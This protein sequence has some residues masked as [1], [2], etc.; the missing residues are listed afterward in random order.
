MGNLYRK[1]VFDKAGITTPPKTWAEF[2]K[3]AATIKAK[4]GSYISNMPGSDPG[5]LIGL[6]W[7]NGA[8]PF[9]YDGKKTLS[10][11][12]DSSQ[13]QQVV[14]FWQ[15]LIHKGQVASAPDFNND[16]YKALTNGN[17]ASWQTAAWAPVF[18]QSAVKS[19][20]GKWRAATLPQWTA[21]ANASGNWG[22]SS[23]AVLTGSKN[24]AAA[25]A[26]A[27]FINSD[28]QSTQMLATEQLLF[29]VTNA[30]LQSSAFID[31]KPS[32]YG[33]QQV[34]KQFSDISNTVDT[35]FEWPPITDYLFSSY[36]TTLGKA[37]ANKG[38]MLAGLT[39]WQNAVVA[40]AK[41]QGFTV[42]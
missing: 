39:D 4:T 40:Y 29:P 19:T 23:D 8:K 26:L 27:K 14:K 41:Q 37:I 5:Q 30:T 34:N 42:K 9:S 1:D 32:F 3:D 12:L 2:A 16:W 7:Q 13:A 38:D 22:G 36:T 24:A 20:A 11:N 18:L 15:D 17:Y 21:G 33:G 31:Q 25:Y 10:I 6:F 35:H 28:P